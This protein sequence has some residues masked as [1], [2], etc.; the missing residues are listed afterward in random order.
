MPTINA[1][2]YVCQ[3]VYAV[4][5]AIMESLSGRFIVFRYINLH[6]FNAGGYDKRWLFYVSKRLNTILEVIH[7][8]D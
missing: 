1:R 4:C 3:C 8:R 7:E 6:T 5:R 2:A